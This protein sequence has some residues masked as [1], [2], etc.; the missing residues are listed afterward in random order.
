MEDDGQGGKKHVPYF[1]IGEQK[2]IEYTTWLY[3][4]VMDGPQNSLPNGVHKYPFVFT[5]PPNLPSSF[6][7]RYGRIRYEIKGNI[8][9]IISLL[10]FLS[11]LE[12]SKAIAKVSQTKYDGDVCD[13]TR[14][15]GSIVSV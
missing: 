6:E 11:S 7:G 15:Q 14:R 1:V 5:V 3:G 8:F 9:Y 4:S 10:N 2:H 13:S 12:P